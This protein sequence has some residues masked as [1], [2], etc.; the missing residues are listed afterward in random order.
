MTKYNALPQVEEIREI[1]YKMPSYEEFMKNYEVDDNLNYADLESSDI[2]YGY[3]PCENSNCSCRCS[4][5]ECICN[6]YANYRGGL[7]EK[8]ARL[9]RAKGKTV[10]IGDNNVKIKGFQHLIHTFNDLTDKG[11]D[12]ITKRNEL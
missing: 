12:P 4:S 7:T 5:C 1:D 11:S 9:V 2:D 10:K 3:G 8:E 6:N